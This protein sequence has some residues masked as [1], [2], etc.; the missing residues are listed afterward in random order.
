MDDSS[1]FRAGM[2]V[3]C[4]D[5]ENI[6]SL[7]KENDV[8]IVRDVSHRGVLIKIEGV[9]FSLASSRFVLATAPPSNPMELRNANNQ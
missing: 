3:V 7:V 1:L 9:P 6:E 8:C 5:N 2:A 4:L